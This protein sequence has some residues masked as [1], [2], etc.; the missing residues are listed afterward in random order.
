MDLF[1]L[2][3]LTPTPLTHTLHTHLSF[4]SYLFSGQSMDLTV[5]F[6]PLTMGN[7]R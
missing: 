4:L 3:T 7:H 6:V 5:E 2:I 1:P